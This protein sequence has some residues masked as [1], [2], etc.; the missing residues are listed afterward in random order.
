[1]R[2]G[3]GE[4]R[5]G[6]WGEQA[7]TVCERE[8]AEGGGWGDIGERAGKLCSR[9][10]GRA[11]RCVVGDGSLVDMHTNIHHLNLPYKP[12]SSRIHA[13]TRSTPRILPSDPP[14]HPALPQDTC[15]S[16]ASHHDPLN[17]M[18]ARASCMEVLLVLL[19]E[20][21]RPVYR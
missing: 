8:R 3:E 6:Q 12:K 2:E 7:E 1:M 5:G 18:P 20:R 11:E 21:H 14:A 17:L 10:V 19:G 9:A 13:P 15:S 4:R 16:P